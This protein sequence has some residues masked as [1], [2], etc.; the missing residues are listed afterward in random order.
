[1][2]LVLEIDVQE[3]ERVNFNSKDQVPQKSQ[4]N[5]EERKGVHKTNFDIFHQA[6]QVRIEQKSD[7]LLFPPSVRQCTPKC[8]TRKASA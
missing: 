8:F 6:Q 5:R 1:M 2:Q 4:T 3:R 7:P